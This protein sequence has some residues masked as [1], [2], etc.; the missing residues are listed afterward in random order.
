MT[1]KNNRSKVFGIGIPR[2]G[3]SILS[4]RVLQHLLSEASAG[5]PSVPVVRQVPKAYAKRR[6]SLHRSISTGKRGVNYK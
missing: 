6:L 2:I 1:T 3:A 4:E 5:S